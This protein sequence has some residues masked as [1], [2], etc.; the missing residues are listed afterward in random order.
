MENLENTPLSLIL[1]IQVCRYGRTY[2]R[3]TRWWLKEPGFASSFRLISSMSDFKK[4][5]LTAHLAPAQ[6]SWYTTLQAGLCRLLCLFSLTLHFLP[7][8]TC[9]I[10]SLPLPDPHFRHRAWG[11]PTCLCSYWHIVNRNSV[12]WQ[13][14]KSLAA[15]CS[16]CHPGS[17]P[18]M[19]LIPV[20]AQAQAH[21]CPLTPPL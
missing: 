15:T 16:P 12:S 19:I 10:A 20:L 1:E 2:V 6:P 5:S 17:K 9:L 3:L 8:L 4:L 21:L 18:T 11:V 7:C 13:R 14:K